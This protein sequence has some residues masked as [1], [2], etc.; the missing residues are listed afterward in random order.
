MLGNIEVTL[1]LTRSSEVSVHPIRRDRH[2]PRDFTRVKGAT[3]LHRQWAAIVL[4]DD[5]AFCVEFAARN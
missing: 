5:R 2:L 4:R 1:V 3:V